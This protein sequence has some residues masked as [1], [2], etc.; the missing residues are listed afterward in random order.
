MSAVTRARSRERQ[1]G[2]AT[3]GRTGH[4]AWIQGPFCGAGHPQLTGPRPDGRG[5][6]EDRGRR[7]PGAADPRSPGGGRPAGQTHSQPGGSN[8][9]SASTLPPAPP[10][11]WV[12]S[13]AHA[14]L[15]HLPSLCDV[16]SQS[17][18]LKLST[19]T[20]QGVAIF[21]GRL[22]GAALPCSRAHVG[23]LS[24]P[25]LGAQGPRPAA[26]I[27]SGPWA[28]GRSPSLTR[29]ARSFAGPGLL[30][31]GKR[32]AERSIP[33]WPGGWSRCWNRSDPGQEGRPP[34]R[35]SL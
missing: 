6:R 5:G 20:G 1:G 33:I 15:R 16:S 11:A 18:S 14:D 12:R 21:K 3:R 2:P 13:P 8:Q 25:S 34:G 28:W 17:E 30:W 4:A 24:G 9:A 23:E 7:L 35:C 19:E 26:P 10:G 31:R 29:G 32:Q 22:R 27:L